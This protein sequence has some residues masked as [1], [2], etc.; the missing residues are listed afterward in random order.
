MG[1]ISIFSISSDL[2]ALESIVNRESTYCF[3]SLWSALGLESISS[4]CLEMRRKIGKKVES[5][6]SENA[7]FEKNRL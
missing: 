4:L 5:Q 7:A 3:L 2:E 1:E 6:F